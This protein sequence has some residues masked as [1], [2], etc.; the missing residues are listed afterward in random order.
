YSHGLVFV[1]AGIVG[2]VFLL[3]RARPIARLAA[4]AI[5]YM[6]LG[7]LCLAYIFGRL[8]DTGPVAG[9]TEWP[10]L[11]NAVNHLLFFPMGMPGADLALAPLVPLLLL[12]P[13]LLGCRIHW[14]NKPAFVPLAILLVWVVAVPETA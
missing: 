7:V 14:Q 2:A 8:T 9:K 4:G 13:W 5:P 12:V 3:L 1:F 6:A 10:G 11:F